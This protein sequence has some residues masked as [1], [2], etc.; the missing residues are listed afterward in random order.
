MS[1]VVIK[2]GRLV[3]PANKIDEQLDLLIVDG[4]V[5]QIARDIQVSDAIE[6]DATGKVVAP[7]LIDMHCHLRVPGN[8]ERE[9]FVTGSRSAAMGGFTTLVAF[10]N[11]HPV[12]DNLTTLEYIKQV[13]ARES[14]VSIVSAGAITKGEEGQELAPMAAMARAGVPLFT[15]DGEPVSS[16]DLMRRA[17]QYSQITGRALSVHEEDKTLTYGGSMN[18][19][20]LSTE[21][22]YFG[23]PG[24]SQTS[25]TARDISICREVGG[26]LHIC[27][28]S[29]GSTIDVLRFG[30]SWGVNV[31][32]EVTPHH[33]TLTEEAVREKGANAKTNPPLATAR[34]VEEIKKGLR[35]GVI[36]VIATDHAPYT[37][38]EKAKD[39]ASAPFG[40]VGLETALSLVI[41]ELVDPGILTLS[42][43]LAK[44]TV[45]PA[46]I[47]TGVDRG[48]LTVGA[49]ADVIVIDMNKN[50]VADPSTY[51]TKGRNCPYGG[52]TIK[53]KVETVLVSGRIILQ[54]GRFAV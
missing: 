21:L 51:Q 32:A 18:A 43:A 4:K 12:V 22:G 48:H 13:A 14:I 31:T 35:D 23:M 24:S 40:L 45:N 11:C 33:F 52:R 27:H 17:L 49:V 3:D 53:G 26:R 38:E 20:A 25:M 46:K 8:P 1:G 34:D 47:L 19:G 28:V 42:D 29:Y 15:D 41:S 7:G 2:N 39:F 54:N 6:I 9:D 44:L 36:D 5:A 10:P 16:A 37:P 50:W 30:K